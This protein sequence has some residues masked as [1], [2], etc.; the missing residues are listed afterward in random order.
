VLLSGVELKADTVSM[1][2]R[3]F[4]RHTGSG[5]D[6]R[7]NVVYYFNNCHGRPHASLF[8][9]GAFYDLWS[10][11]ANEAAHAENLHKNLKV[12]DECVVATRKQ[13]GQ[14]ALT[15][16][17]FV[18]AEDKPNPDDKGMPCRVLFGAAVKSEMFSKAEAAHHGIYTR[19]FNRNGHFNRWAVLQR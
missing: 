10:T 5:R 11:I 19:F 13:D 8:G 15:W 3:A 16:Y 7:G 12:G 9:S 2:S 14:I 17:S 4:G 18:R 6:V 1:T